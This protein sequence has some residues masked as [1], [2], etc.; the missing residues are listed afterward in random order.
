MR[1]CAADTL[2][3]LAMIRVDKLR[4]PFLRQC[5]RQE[6][7]RRAVYAQPV[8]HAVEIF[9]HI[10]VVGVTFVDNHNLARDTE[11]PQHQMLLFES[12]HE[13]LVDRADYK[14]GEQ[15]LLA[16]AEPTVY[17][18]IAVSAI[19]VNI[20]LVN[21]C[22]AA[23]QRA[24]VLVEF[25]HAV[26]ETNRVCGLLRLALRPLQKSRKYSVRCSL[27]RQTEKQSSALM[28]CR[29]DIGGG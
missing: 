21:L 8:Q 3:R 2:S 12:D 27:R 28:L 10:R 23:E 1:V 22:P 15:R 17:P 11:M 29:Y 4:A 13:Q 25:S 16:T 5:R 18:D 24:I 20:I 7:N 6:Y 14:I 9:V 26:R 19:A